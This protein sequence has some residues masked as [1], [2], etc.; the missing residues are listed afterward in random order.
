MVMAFEIWPFTFW[1]FRI[2]IEEADGKRI[3]EY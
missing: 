2:A 1:W 3:A